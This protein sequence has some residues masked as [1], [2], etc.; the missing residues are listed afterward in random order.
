[1][2]FDLK[3]LVAK[4]I[5]IGGP[6]AIAALTR[7]LVGPT[8]APAPT[9]DVSGMPGALNDAVTSMGLRL[10]QAEAAISDHRDLI[11]THGARISAVY[12]QVGA[13]IPARVS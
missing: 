9:L 6:I 13:P 3:L 11:D 12:D 4:A 10:A 1:M 8:P 7:K 2:G 5:E